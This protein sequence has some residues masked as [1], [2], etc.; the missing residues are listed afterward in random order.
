MK[1]IKDI[2]IQTDSEAGSKGRFEVN[3]KSSER[4]VEKE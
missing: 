2:G 3:K 4:P 1:K